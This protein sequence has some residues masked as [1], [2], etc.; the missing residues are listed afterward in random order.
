MASS[1]AETPE[2]Q[3]PPS[4]SGLSPSTKDEDASLIDDETQKLLDQGVTGHVIT[5]VRRPAKD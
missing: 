3:A 5:N 4:S 2:K 1:S